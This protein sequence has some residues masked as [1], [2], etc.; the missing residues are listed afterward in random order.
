MIVDGGLALATPE[1]LLEQ[2]VGGE[3]TVRGDGGRATWVGPAQQGAVRAAG[4]GM[5][6]P[7]EA[8]AD[9][10]L[11]V[12]RRHGHELLGIQETQTLLEGLGRT[13]P[14]LVREVV[15]KL[16]SPVLL[17]DVLRRLAEEGVSVRGLR[18]ILG[19][20]A[21]LAP[22]ERDPAALTELVRAALRRQITATYVGADGTLGV[23]LLDGLI[24]GDGARGGAG[25]RDGLPRWRSSPPSRATSSRPWPA[26]FPARRGSP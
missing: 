3:P 1:R 23:Y 9:H 7:D 14:A 20:L 2:G 18:E 5:L 10:L 12:L 16:I 25:D 22:R 4:V 13:H 6:A 8:I 19:A 26:R 24:R 15:P 11:Y 21:A 17:A